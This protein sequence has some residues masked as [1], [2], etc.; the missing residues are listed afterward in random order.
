MTEEKRCPRYRSGDQCRREGGSAEK[1]A[2]RKFTGSRG[3]K[4][5]PYSRW[6]GH[7]EHE[8]QK[9]AGEMEVGEVRGRKEWSDEQRKWSGR[10]AVELHPCGRRYLVVMGVQYGVRKS[11]RTIR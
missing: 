1:G 6:N 11:L 10:L 7:F 8:T 5:A 9:E 3:E 2:E 4:R